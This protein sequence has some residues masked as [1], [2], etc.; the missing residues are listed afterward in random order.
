MKYF[1]HGIIESLNCWMDNHW[2]ILR[3]ISIMGIIVICFVGYGV[4]NGERVNT[5][6]TQLLDASIE[7]RLEVTN[8]YLW[9]E[10]I[11]GGDRSNDL[12]VVWKHLDQAEQHTNAML[13]GIKENSLPIIPG[14]DVRL[15]QKIMVLKSKLVKLREITEKR[16][17]LTRYAGPGTE[18]D[19][20][21]HAILENFV[22]KGEELE[23]NLQHAMK[24]D[25]HSIK[26][27]KVVLIAISLVLFLLFGV[28]FYRS[29]RSREQEF[30]STFEAQ[31]TQREHIIR[32]KQ[33][34]Q[35]LRESEE[36]KKNK[37]LSPIQNLTS[38][39]AHEINNPNNVISLNLPILRDYLQDM[40]PILDDFAR[41]HQ[42]LEI[43]GMPYS[44]FRKDVFNLIES[45]N[46]SS[47][48]INNVVCTLKAFVGPSNQIDLKELELSRV[49][50]K[51]A[52]NKSNENNK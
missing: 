47:K 7:I 37:K 9:F 46:R 19:Q 39:I 5:K 28:P 33:A 42:N 23:T 52:S 20:Q 31:D 41:N 24:K 22:Y 17:A 32:M 8:A 40:M 25:L 13:E 43:I 29:E 27:I 11:L 36:F 49:L 10:E 50:G 44:W 51:L 1:G 3:I 26:S 48:R 14:D 4:Y 38:S 15:R 35:G 12:D 34:G 16:L 21:H 45:C 18:V 6:Y 2:R 30:T